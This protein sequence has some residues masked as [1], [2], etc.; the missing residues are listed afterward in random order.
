[1]E[2]LKNEREELEDENK[3]LQKYKGK[4][5]KKYGR[6]R[7]NFLRMGEE[8]KNKGQKLNLVKTTPITI[9][10]VSKKQKE[11]DTKNSKY[12]KELIQGPLDVKKIKF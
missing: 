12:F 1:M 6:M 10:R 4:L 8:N 5:Q 3:K 9:K 7:E 2:A 11:L